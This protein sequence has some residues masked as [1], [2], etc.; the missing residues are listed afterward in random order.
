MTKYRIEFLKAKNREWY[1]RVFH[2]NGNEICR[3]SETYKRKADCVRGFR[4][5][6]AGL[7]LI[8]P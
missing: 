3:S 8:G 1:W 7:S 4:R 5:F 6:A 2:R